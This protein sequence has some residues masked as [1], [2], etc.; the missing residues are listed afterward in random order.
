MP[1][2]K[3]ITCFK[4][5]SRTCFYPK[6]TSSP[7]PPVSQASQVTE[8][9]A[10]T[11]APP[12]FAGCDMAACSDP[13]R[14]GQPRSGKKRRVSW[15]QVMQEPGLHR[16]EATRTGSWHR[17]LP[18]RPV[19][20]HQAGGCRTPLSW[21][22]P[23]TRCKETDRLPDEPTRKGLGFFCFVFGLFVCFLLWLCFLVTKA[24]FDRSAALEDA[25]LLFLPAPPSSSVSPHPCL[26]LLHFCFLA[27]YRTTVSLFCKLLFSSVPTSFL[28]RLPRGSII[29][30]LL[31]PF[32]LHV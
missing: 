20:A 15:Q 13:V 4:S 22:T 8:A 31:L 18:R 17:R 2:R 19:R 29:C 6:S 24:A 9:P 11:S 5:A 3:A 26:F 32:F 21:P 7:V 30:H 10:Q 25:H 23:S 14:R 1:R 28:C 27:G 12:A 16:T